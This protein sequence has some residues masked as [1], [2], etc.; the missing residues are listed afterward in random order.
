M[1]T[2]INHLAVIMDG[3][4]RW[5]ELQGLPRTRG[6][7]RGAEVV[8]DVT[9]HA[10]ARGIRYLTLF[11]FSSLNWG[12]PSAEV[13]ALMDLLCSFLTEQEEELIQEGIRLRGIGER[14]M[15]PVHVR[16]LLERVERNT[17][18]NNKLLLSLAISYDGRRDLVRAA[19]QL[20]A[21]AQ[22]GL[23]LPADV[24]EELILNELSTQDSPDVDLVI[25]TSGERRLSGFLPI[26]ACYAELV[27]IDKLWPEF[28]TDDLDEALSEY[29]L[30]Q[31]RFGLTGHQLEVSLCPT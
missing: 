3:N 25:R 24:H 26:E 31:R 1:K 15:L 10:R 18:H 2:P 23:L 12:R 4:G 11:A 6:H 5:A 16:E 28:T 14:E 21:L 8:R 30:R 19:Q 20:V 22:K 9:R 27:F 29:E 7:E 17:A 13:G